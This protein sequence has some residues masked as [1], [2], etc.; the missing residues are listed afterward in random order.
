LA[1]Q[2]RVSED[3]IMAATR[4]IDDTHALVVGYCWRSSMVHDI[5]HGGHAIDDFHTLKERVIVMRVDYQ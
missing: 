4:C 3:M 5:S 1:G 2:L